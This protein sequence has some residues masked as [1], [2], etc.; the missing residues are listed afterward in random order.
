MESE[1]VAFQMEQK[2]S[3]HQPAAFTNLFKAMEDLWPRKRPKHRIANLETT[4]QTK[5]DDWSASTNGFEH[6]HDGKR[7]IQDG[8]TPIADGTVPANALSKCR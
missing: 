6:I 8:T 4:Y 5:E 7:G 1:E 2:P 3:Q